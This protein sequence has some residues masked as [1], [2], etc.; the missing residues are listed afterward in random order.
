[1]G[2]VFDKIPKEVDWK[3]DQARKAKLDENAWRD[4]RIKILETRVD[5]LEQKVEAMYNWYRYEYRP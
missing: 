3:E 1:M 2:I 5:E 4:E